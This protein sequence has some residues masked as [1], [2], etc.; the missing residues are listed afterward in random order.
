MARL[1][2]QSDRIDRDG[3]FDVYAITIF[4]VSV[5][6][7]RFCG[8]T[9]L[10]HGSDLVHSFY[11]MDYQTVNFEIQRTENVSQRTTVFSGADPRTVHLQRFL[12]HTRH[13]HRTQRKSD[14]LDLKI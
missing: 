7:D 13:D 2:F 4:V 3:I 1:D 8:R 12:D 9:D 5:S 10:D 14:L 11:S 6:P